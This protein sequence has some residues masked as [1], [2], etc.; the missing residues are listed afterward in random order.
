MSR[1]SEKKIQQEAGTIYN[2]DNVT[3][4]YA[5]KVYLTPE[6]AAPA[7]PPA[8]SSGKAYITDEK[9][10]RYLLDDYSDEDEFEIYPDRLYVLSLY[11]IT[12]KDSHDHYTLFDY[13]TY[14]PMVKAGR[15]NDDIWSVPY[16]ITTIDLAGRKVRKVKEIR[17]VY[18]A[19][20]EGMGEKLSI[21]EDNLFYNLG[22]FYKEIDKGR[23]YI[24][25]KKSTTEPDKMRCNYVREFFVH[26]IDSTGVLNLADPE[27][28]HQHRYAPFGMIDTLPV[29]DGLLRFMGKPVPN[30]VSDILLYEKRRLLK[31]AIKVD[32]S[33]LVY[34][35]KGFIFSITLMNG[36][37]LIQATC[38]LSTLLEQAVAY[39]NLAQYS[40]DGANLYG[41][42]PHAKY[43]FTD[44]L[45]RMYEGL[46]KI[47]PDLTICCTT[48]YSSFSFG[49]LLGLS[50][51]IPTF[52]GEGYEQLLSMDLGAAYA[53]RQIDEKPGILF[54]WDMKDD[55]RIKFAPKGAQRFKPESYKEENRSMNFIVWPKE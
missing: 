5:D 12:L 18:A 49:R 48:L 47:H 38:L 11:F 34:Q 10:P 1:M 25:Y 53:W 42:V 23:E 4:L 46:S 3:N 20:L 37:K 36:D 52:S 28:L 8:I 41:C 22:I 16:T 50:S 39:G 17:A 30:N 51:R 21:L 14:A 31:N 13:V 2:V 29:R 43:N 15:V 7:S 32:K 33:D 26:D 9:K 45:C 24:E 55:D 35:I 44:L 19:A 40:I 6:Q 54:A 27:C